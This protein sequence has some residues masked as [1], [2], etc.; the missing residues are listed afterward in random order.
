MFLIIEIFLGV[1]SI[2]LKM[3]LQIIAVFQ[4]KSRKF[5][6]ELCIRM[7]CVLANKSG[8]IFA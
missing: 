6:V 7:K 3:E 8:T 2:I 4:K 1:W 5:L